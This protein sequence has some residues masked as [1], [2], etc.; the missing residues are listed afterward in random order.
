VTTLKLN[1]TKL[2]MEQQV[3]KD[4]TEIDLVGRRPHK[5]DT[6]WEKEEHI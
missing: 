5:A 4:A 2:E 1:G 3:R 6:S